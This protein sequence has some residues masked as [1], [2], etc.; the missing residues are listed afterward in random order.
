MHVHYALT[1]LSS[2]FFSSF[3]A[4]PPNHSKNLLLGVKSKVEV[5][6]AHDLRDRDIKHLKIVSE[7]DQEIPQSQTADNPVAP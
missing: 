7:Y 5:S 1:T 3:L 2:S 6:V 4:V